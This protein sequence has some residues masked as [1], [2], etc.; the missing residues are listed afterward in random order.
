M[1]YLN[2]KYLTTLP[3]LPLMNSENIIIVRMCNEYY[4]K[5]LNK[6]LLNDVY[7]LIFF[8]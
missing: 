7:A 3:L 2:T 1:H 4:T 6:I 8:F 5:N